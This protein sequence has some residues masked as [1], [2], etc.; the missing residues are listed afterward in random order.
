MCMW[1]HM[2]TLNDDKTEALLIGSNNRL[3]PHSAVSIKVSDVS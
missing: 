2:L 3:K 1:F